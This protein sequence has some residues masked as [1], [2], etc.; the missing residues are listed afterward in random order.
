MTCTPDLTSHPWRLTEHLLLE[1][2]DLQ[3]F[4]AV[5]M[6]WMCPRCHTRCWADGMVH[7]S[8]PPLTPAQWECYTASGA[9]PWQ[10]QVERTRREARQRAWLHARLKEDRR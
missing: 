1:P 8:T 5:W 9:D 3:G 4:A 7:Q 10:G 2:W 6:C